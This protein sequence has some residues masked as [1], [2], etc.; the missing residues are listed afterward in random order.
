VS[1]LKDTL[2]NNPGLNGAG[3]ARMLAP[4]GTTWDKITISLE[5]DGE[6]CNI[7]VA[8][9]RHSYKY[10]N[11]KL[12]GVFVNKRD[13]K[14]N[15]QWKL[16]KT[17]AKENGRIGWKK[18]GVIKPNTLA[19]GQPDALAGADYSAE[20]AG[21]QIQYPRDQRTINKFKTHI[22]LLRQTLQDIFGISANPISY[23]KPAKT[24]CTCFEISYRFDIPQG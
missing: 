11:P 2:D 5:P 14:P 17:F 13:N 18:S 15:K 24:Y 9:E 1:T 4:P 6:C 8:D 20:T 22:K 19:H 21:V 10:D 7:S 3:I 12:N 23:D 16:L